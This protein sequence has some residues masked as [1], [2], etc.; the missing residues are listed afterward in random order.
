MY[1]KI[2]VPLDG[3]ELAESVLPHMESIATRYKAEIHLLTVI[4]K[5]FVSQT[6]SDVALTE[7]IV[8]KAV[9]TEAA[10]ADSYLN[11][12]AKGLE[13]KRIKVHTTVHM[14]KP[15]EEIVNHAEKS[16]CDLII[17]ASHG[18]SGPSRWTHGSVAEK[19]F[20]SSCVP[21]LMVQAP[22]CV[23]RMSI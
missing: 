12:V 14:G 4:H 8:E 5:P 10:G 21:V 2:L 17:M 13:G 18:R 9:G 3:S 20:R 11:K 23:P 15:A 16:G 1:Q 22:G 6:F 19:V 7:P